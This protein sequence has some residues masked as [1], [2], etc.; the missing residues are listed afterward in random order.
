L[1]GTAGIDVLGVAAR[2]AS[3]IRP[4]QRRSEIAVGGNRPPHHRGFPLMAAM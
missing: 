4:E 2:T 1:G 3:A